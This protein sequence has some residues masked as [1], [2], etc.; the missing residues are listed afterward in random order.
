MCNVQ[1]QISGINT[2]MEQDNNGI[3]KNVNWKSDPEGWVAGVG[4]LI[5]LSLMLLSI[6]SCLS[7]ELA[8]R[9]C[10]ESLTQLNDEHIQQ[11]VIY[12]WQNLKRGTHVAKV[13]ESEAFSTF[14]EALQK[15]KLANPVRPQTI[16]KLDIV[17]RMQDGSEIELD[18]NLVLEPQPLIRFSRIFRGQAAEGYLLRYCGSFESMDL[19]S[20]IVERLPE[21]MKMSWPNEAYPEQ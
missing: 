4:L 19:F 20:W 14:V 7:D 13:T 18:A 17:V 12:R 10:R 8:I 15:L 3:D 5:I 6:R 2:P 16:Q 1:F 21:S 11:I 9:D